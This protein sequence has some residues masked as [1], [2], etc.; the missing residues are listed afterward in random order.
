VRVI[1]LHPDVLVVFSRVWQTTCTIVRGDAQA[2]HMGGAEEGQMSGAGDDNP[3]VVRM[4]GESG[5]G[6]AGEH[7]HLGEETFV[8][9]SPI[10]PDELE[11]LPALLEQS[12]FPAPSGLLATHADWDHLLGRLA[13][14]D[15]ALGC[16]ETS[17][18]RLQSN[19]GAAQRELRAFDERHYVR[20]PRP[21]ALGSVQALD[22]PGRCEI[23]SRELVLHPADGHTGDGIAIAIGWAGVLVIGDYLSTVE[24]PVLGEGGSIASYL[25]TLKRL[26]ALVPTVEYIVSGHGPVLDPERALTVLEEDV[27]YLTALGDLGAAAELP[28]GRRT[29][30]QRAIHTAN[31]ERVMAG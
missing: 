31:V 3:V 13:F 10:F 5:S 25:A 7:A 8:I 4:V 21:L 2:R 23:G 1:S 16:A 6:A 9:D 15:A 24:I 18:R 29:T 28:Q 11:V 20:R 14:P 27:A 19:P 30:A 26:R 22:A 12:R 17:A